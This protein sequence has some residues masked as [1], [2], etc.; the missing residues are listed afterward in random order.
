MT[1]PTINDIRAAAK[2]L[3]GKARKT[4]LIESRLLNDRLGGRLLFKPEM[5]QN[6][7]SFKF[8]GAYNFVSSLPHADKPTSIIAYSSGNHAQGVAAAA[9]AFNIPAMIIMPRDAPAIKIANTRALGAD[10]VFYDRQLESREEIGEMMQAELGATLIRPYDDAH[11]IAGQGTVGLEITEQTKAMNV[12]PDAV[13]C[14]CG[15]GGLISG[16]A[17]A[18]EAES[19]GTLIYAVEPEDFDD[20]A[21]SLEAGKRLCNDNTA[22][23]ICDALLTPEP[24]EMTFAINKRLL[25][26]SLRVPDDAVRAAMATAFNDL[27]VVAEPG[28]AVGLAAVLSGAYDVRDKTVV[29]VMS[30]GNVDKEV[31]REVLA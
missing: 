25:S 22:Q 10:I 15:G 17:L 8:R 28:G 12:S 7:G 27:K 11:I 6:T 26:G 20:T 30:G 4:P 16:T 18:L 1:E 24:G 21:R 23:S 14:P 19:P 9:R 13:L 5:L 29:I 31:F 3:D 2:R